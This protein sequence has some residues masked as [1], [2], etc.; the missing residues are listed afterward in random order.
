MTLR[1]GEDKKGRRVILKLNLGASYDYGKALGSN[2][3]ICIPCG[4][5]YIFGLLSHL[6]RNT[7]PRKNI[8]NLGE[9]MLKG[10]KILVGFFSEGASFE[11]GE[12]IFEDFG[13]IGHLDF[14]F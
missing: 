11:L 2:P 5:P 10:P 1:L 14:G 8:L 6:Q 4:L 9:I 7:K 3:I 13:S 12:T